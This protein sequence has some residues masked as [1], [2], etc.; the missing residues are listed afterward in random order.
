MSDSILHNQTNAEYHEHPALG[1]TTI[2]EWSLKSPAHA[3]YGE[4]TINSYIAAE[5][6]AAHFVFEGK[7]EMVLCGGETRR[8]SAWT[9]LEKQ[10]SNIGGVALPVKAYNHAMAAGNS[11]RNHCIAHNIS[12]NE[13]WT[14]PSI[15]T[16][17]K[18]TGI[19]VKTRPDYYNPKTG[20]LLDLKTTQSAKPS[21]FLRQFYNL[22]YDIQCAAYSLFCEA[23]GLK[24]SD[25]FIFVAVEKLPPYAAQIFVVEQDVL[26]AAK[27]RVEQI[28]HEIATSRKTGNITTGW[29]PVFKINFNSN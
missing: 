22:G 15:Y 21:D 23:A 4:R 3:M 20:D 5:G 10:A 29:P 18:P 19:E 6:T 11:A 16:T 25:R 8:G 17:H 28:L 26:D 14:E 9:E 13:V 7:P 27:T 12:F 24:V 1:S 2:K